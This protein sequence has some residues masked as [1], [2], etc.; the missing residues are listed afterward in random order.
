[1]KTVK[2]IKKNGVLLSK[3]DFLNLINIIE[4]KKLG[5]YYSEGR[6]CYY[7]LTHSITINNVEYNYLKIKGNG[8]FN[9]DTF[10]P[11]SDQ[12]FIRRDL[13]YGFNDNSKPILIK[14]DSAPL[15]GMVL[16]RAL[17]EYE[18]FTFLINKNVSTLYPFCIF[19]YKT[20]KFKKDYLGVSVAFSEEPYR[21]DKLLFSSIPKKYLKFYQK[22]FFS[23]FGYN[24]DLSFKDRVKLIQNIAYKYA[25]EIRKFCDSGLYIHSGGWS[26]IQYSFKKKNIVLVDMD[27]SK[28]NVLNDDKLKDRDLVSNIYRLFINLYNP[29][30]IKCYTPEILKKTNYCY[31]LLKGFYYEMEDEPLLLVSKK[32]NNF[33][34]KNCFNNIKKIERDMLKISEKQVQKMELNIFDF[35]DYCMQQIYKNIKGG[36]NK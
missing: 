2:I 3:K 20:P 4:F 23:E 22:V 31:Y 5:K 11:P 15:G 8:F 34:I 13:H 35:Y 28:R 32:I 29:N 27:S 16:K 18:N 1:M 36:D 9:N 26:N 12:E 25:R 21:F 24:S 14:S 7:K 17:Q 33:Y 30:C 6:T 19:K 10:T